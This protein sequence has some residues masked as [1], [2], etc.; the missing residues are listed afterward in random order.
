MKDFDRNLN[1]VSTTLSEEAAAEGNYSLT[2]EGEAGHTYL[3]TTGTTNGLRFFGFKLV[4]EGDEEPTE[5]TTET[6]TEYGD[7]TS[8]TTSKDEDSS[9][10]TTESGES[11]GS[12]SV[13]TGAVEFYTTGYSAGDGEVYLSY[14]SDTNTYTIVD[15][16]TGAAGTA[17]Y[18]LEGVNSDNVS[19]SGTF[20]PSTS[21]TS[22]S[23]VQLW[24]YTGATDEELSQLF[25][26][27]S[28]TGDSG[29]TFY[30]AA[31]G[32]YYDTGVEITAGETYEY[33]FTYNFSTGKA[34][35]VLN[36]TEVSA[37]GIYVSEIS[38]IRFV[39]ATAARNL[40][41]TEPVVSINQDSGDSG[42]GRSGSGDETTT[43]PSTET[44]TETEIDEGNIFTPER[45][46]SE[47]E[48]MYRNSYF[49]LTAM[50]DLNCLSY[51]STSGVSTSAAI[52]GINKTSY[53]F[54]FSIETEQ[55]CKIT[56]NHRVLSNKD[57][58]IVKEDGSGG[59]ISVA[60][61]ANFNDSTDYVETYFMAEAGE[62]YYFVNHGTNG[63][64]YSVEADSTDSVLS[65]Y[66]YSY[67]GGVL[68]VSS[69][70]GSYSAVPWYDYKDSITS[71][72]V[73]DGVTELQDYIFRDLSQAKEVTLPDSLT[74]IGKGAFYGC[75]SL[76]T[77]NFGSSISTIDN[78]AFYRSGISGVVAIP[79]DV[80]DISSFAFANCPN[81]T[82]I[83][84]GTGASTIWDYAFAYS[85]ALEKAYVPDNITYI[86]ENIF[87]NYE[88]SGFVDVLMYVIADSAA[89][90]YAEFNNIRYTLDNYFNNNILYVTVTDPSGNTIESGFT[91]NWYEYGSDTVVATGTR[92][93]NADKS[94][95][96]EY[97][98]VLGDDLAFIYKTP[99]RTLIES[100][101]LEG[102]TIGDVY[103]LEELSY[104]T[105]SGKTADTE[106]NILSGAAVTV[107]QTKNSTKK[108]FTAVSDEN[109]NFSVEILDMAATVVFSLSDYYNY[110]LSYV[111]GTAVDSDL[112]LGTVNMK[113]LP[114]NKI[115]LDL[116]LT[117]AAKE[118]GTPIVTSITDTNN[119]SFTLY[120]ET[121]GCYI[122]SFIV[123]YP[124]IVL[125]DSDI[126]AGD[127]IIIEAADGNNNMTAEAVSCYAASGGESAS[128][129]V[130]FIQNGCVEVS[131]ISG[132]TATAM[133]FDTNGEIVKTYKAESYFTSDS[134]A[135]GSYTIVFIKNTNILKSVPRLST[136][137][138]LGL[139]EGTDYVM[140][141]MEIYNGVITEIS[142]I[143]FPDFDESALYYT[144]DSSTSLT[145]NTSSAVAGRY[146]TIKAEYE[147][148]YKYSSSNEQ[149]IIELPEG[150]SL[151]SSSVAL[152]GK[153]SSYNQSG[154][155]I[156][157]T[158]NKSSGT[159]RFYVLANEK[160]SYNLNGY[161]S[162]YIDG[163]SVLQP[164]GS[165]NLDIKGASINVPSS[166][167]QTNVTVSGTALSK[168]TITVYDNNTEVGT[169]S[170]NSNGSWS[171][172]FD[173]VNPYSHSYHQ[174]YAVIEN[175]SYSSAIYTDVSL[176]SYDSNSVGLSKITMYNTA[177]PA[178]SQ[179]AVEY[180]TVFDFI[181]PGTTPVYR[182]WP[183]YP[184]FT[185]K[186]E[187]ADGMASSAKNVYVVT[188]NSSGEE[189]YIACSYD[190]ASDVWLG[191]CD[192]SS[193][194]IPTSV[195]AKYDTDYMFQAVF[196][197]EL[198]EAETSLLE[199]VEEGIEEYAEDGVDCVD[200]LTTDEGYEVS[201]IV[202]K[203]T[204]QE[205]GY[206]ITYSLSY[207]AV[208]IT[209]SAF[210]LVEDAGANIYISC[211]AAD[212]YADYIVVDADN[213][214][215][216][217]FIIV[218]DEITFDD[219]EETEAEEE[220][221]AE[222]ETEAEDAAADEEES[223]SET[224]GTVLISD[225][226]LS[227]AAF[228]VALLSDDDH[229]NIE[230]ALKVIRT[231]GLELY[232]NDGSF[233]WSTLKDSAE[234]ALRDEVP[235]ADELFGALDYTAL[236]NEVYAF[237]RTISNY[238]TNIT[239][240]LS[241]KCS[242]G[243]DKLSQSDQLRML[244]ALQQTVS[245][246]EN[247]MQLLE[248]R[249][250]QYSKR[251]YFEL[252]KELASCGIQTKLK[253]AIKSAEAAKEA[254]KALTTAQTTLLR[255]NA[256]NDFI[257]KSSEV[258]DAGT[259][260]NGLLED[261]G[262]I[263]EE[264]NLLDYLNNAMEYVTTNVNDFLADRGLVSDL[265][266]EK[267]GLENT[268]RATEADIRRDFE[269]I[270][271]KIKSLYSDCD[272]DDDD[273]DEDKP[274]EE[275]PPS[276]A[277]KRF[278]RPLRLYLRGCSFKQN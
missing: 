261:A 276:P 250:A 32:E 233:S 39:T 146:I 122:T 43:E 65:G 68:T 262:V 201:A 13:D 161:L 245:Y 99:E 98:I 82:G 214:T 256:V 203:K 21:N 220:T 1:L 14:D 110:T 175:S 192:Y 141:G 20:S 131:G 51:L 190:S 170:S 30:F 225:I 270:R 178:T 153:S 58:W 124:Y 195:G 247:Q 142:G 152:N 118:N 16:D 236:A 76:E 2:F 268:I 55:D 143:T 75:S 115:Y 34:A 24:G 231:A 211:E 96:F 44:T 130:E 103:T 260:I 126:S 17:V 167:S 180:E 125:D 116:K 188:T 189:T 18:Y 81:L 191:S 165:L 27:R 232:N 12:S 69:S 40:S 136:L 265:S 59:Y 249:L 91:V 52:D 275:T 48:T 132:N 207:D 84:A 15:E 228:S 29:K 74:A 105:L 206:L 229:S 166:T 174:I 33:E 101:G 218:T 184:T 6:T 25:A 251:V 67:S 185:F 45:N 210:S 128:A 9:E 227:D 19:V 92:L 113:P 163:S 200:I 72:V 277:Y 255:Y 183:T 253:A 160:G 90:S 248:E 150:I 87:W 242:D 254:E 104:I 138:E 71:I 235:F 145:T 187:F 64:V 212:E 226:C 35:L 70:S 266:A 10:T 168:S 234:T 278:T 53:R 114:S 205:I 38:E 60:A 50:Q 267:E 77:V 154:N 140:T 157:I 215:A 259:A 63:G 159:V 149:I 213:E 37:E 119:L 199:T 73:E 11:G 219:E 272:D 148:E 257:E 134:L 269:A 56:I 243:S 127:E 217:R 216:T 156:T 106:G 172:S 49:T 62:T 264:N 107:T 94:K 144:V 221:G 83:E 97:Q 173:L 196:R 182:Y 47:G 274:F 42:S 147:I 241:E 109:G 5:A 54:A 177:H 23:L 26:I 176:L 3:V 202:D 89:E 169:V 239:Y 22:W 121:K 108:T 78:F 7:D 80:C 117:G 88:N 46:Y 240:M 179:N 263:D 273:G 223:L 28:I 123:Q 171:L 238:E 244:T 186:V 102:Q 208:D 194:D 204:S 112:D 222:E 120:N 252:G 139:S 95:Q 224:D 197:T 237:E 41:F 57:T 86:G 271:D 4:K 158:S 193:Y 258:L 61:D 162:A 151:V 164:I 66:S 36:G 111:S 135:Q 31:D 230:T 8:E 209:D 198:V 129:A 85:E 133:I 79:D 137:D 181:N 155:T 246:A 93:N 100:E